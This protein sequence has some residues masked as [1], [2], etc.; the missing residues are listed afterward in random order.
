L[1]LPHPDYLLDKLTASQLA[2][3]KAF[4]SLEPIGEYR[5]DYRFSY[6]A[7]LITNLAIRINGKSGAKLTSIKDFIFDWDADNTTKGTQSMEEMKNVLQ[8]IASFGN[9][10]KDK[11]DRLEARRTRKP[12]RNNQ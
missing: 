10:T 1:G 5:D 4:N 12:I 2:E 6:M 3:W 7:S 9:N 11:K 8:S